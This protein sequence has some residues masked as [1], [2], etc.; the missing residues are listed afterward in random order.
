MSEKTPPPL[1][2][3]SHLEFHY[4]KQAPLFSEISFELS[5]GTAL[6]IIGP[7]GAGKTTLLKL[8]GGLLKPTKG[9]IVSTQNLAYLPQHTNFNLTLPLTVEECIELGTIGRSHSFSTKDVL[10]MVSLTKIKD[11]LISTL[12]GGQLRRTFLGKAIIGRPEVLLLDEPT[13]TLD[14]QGIDELMHILKKLRLEFKTAVIMVDHNMSYTLPHCDRI[15]C[16]GNKTHF[17][18]PTE[19]LTK[20][21]LQN[22]YH[23]EWE[24]LLIHSDSDKRPHIFCEDEHT[25][26]HTLLKGEKD[27]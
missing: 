19:R 3:V 18:C 20:D 13:N 5:P 8:L 27:E 23:C 25:H 2:K 1:Y 21:A 17:H 11:Q 10:S 16:L 7:N 26:E 9:K 14:G 22:I 12:S 15:L 6:G 24:H 4:A